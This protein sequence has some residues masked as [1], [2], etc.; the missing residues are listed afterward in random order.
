MEDAFR[1]LVDAAVESQVK[2]VA[3][4]SIDSAQ[5]VRDILTDRFGAGVAEYA[6]KPAH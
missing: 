4:T 6:V 5:V 2:V 3:V 1:Y